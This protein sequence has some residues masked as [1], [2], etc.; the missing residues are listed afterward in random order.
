MTPGTRL[1]PYEIVEAI[2]AGGMGEVYRARDPRLGRDV[3]IKVSAAHFSDRFERE[4]RAIAA[5]NHPHICTLHDVGP[6]LSR[7]GAGRGADAGGSDPPGAH[8]ARRIA[9]DCPADCRRP[10]G[11]AR[12]GHRAP[13]ATGVSYARSPTSGPGRLL[14]VREGTL[15]AQPFDDRRLALAGDAVPVTERMSVY[16]DSAP[17]STSFNNILVYRAAD[18]E[19][20]LTWVDRQG[21]V[22]GRVSEPGRYAS[23]ALSPDGTRAV[24]SRT[25]PRNRANADLWMLDLLRGGSPTRFTFLPGLRADGPVWSPDGRRIAFFRFGASGRIGLYQKVVGSAQDE[26]M[27][28]A[29]TRGLMTPTSWS[30]DGRFVLYAET[31]SDDELGPVGG[32]GRTR[33][34]PGA[35]GQADPVR[36]DAVRRRTG[37]LLSRWTMDRVRLERIRHERSVRPRL[38]DGSQRRIRQR[39]RGASWSRKAVDRPRAG[40]AMARSCFIS[41][42]PAR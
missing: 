27:L 15:M 2:G 18:P 26:E 38:Q 40:G 13:Y 42:R 7:H 35:R 19:S 4:A 24:A 6:E 21:N 1:G 9:A 39:W 25:N 16:L 34:L 12:E 31:A 28:Q 3:A 10:P 41:R 23:V 37:P 33:G 5:L 20:P 17:F 11:G 32:P 36:A 22:A 14:F 29:A 8:R 30:P